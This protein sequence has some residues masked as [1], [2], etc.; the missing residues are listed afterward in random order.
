MIIMQMKH[1]VFEYRDAK[2]WHKYRCSIRA[3]S[4]E[5]AMCWLYYNA[6]EQGHVVTRE[7]RID[8]GAINGRYLKAIAIVAAVWLAC[9]YFG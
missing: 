8:N 1:F 4:H 5:E 7:R 6:A 3:Y 9:S 2:T